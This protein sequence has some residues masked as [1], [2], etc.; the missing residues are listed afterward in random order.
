MVLCRKSV[1]WVVFEQNVDRS[2]N[3]SFDV[4]AIATSC[5]IMVWKN[6]S[7]ASRPWQKSEL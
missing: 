1:L 7:F 3:L 2:K 5:T 4:V 6:D